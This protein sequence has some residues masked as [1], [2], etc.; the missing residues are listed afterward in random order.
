DRGVSVRGL[1]AFPWL[2]HETTIFGILPLAVLATIRGLPSW[3][4]LV[5]AGIVGAALVG[6]W[7]LYQ[8]YMDP[9]GN[10]LTK[11]AF[12]GVTEIDGRSTSQAIVDS[13]RD[14][15]FSGVVENKKRNF[16]VMTVGEGENSFHNIEGS[17]R[18]AFSGDF[19]EAIRLGRGLRFF[20][21]LLSL[22]PLA[23]APV[24]MLLAR[25]WN[26]PVSDDWSFG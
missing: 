23:L 6:P 26:R 21:L 10:R 16:V 15:G 5:T 13:Y 14:A 22:G 11:E 17:I 9:P 7:A 12:A 1:L 4:W 20:P 18:Q 24:L 2:P 25:M 19:S 8:R 3:R